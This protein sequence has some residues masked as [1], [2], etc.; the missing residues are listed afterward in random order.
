MQTQGQKFFTTQEIYIY[1][2]MKKKCRVTFTKKKRRVTFTNSFKVFNAMLHSFFFYF[3][4]T[5]HLYWTSWQSFNWFSVMITVW[6]KIHHFDSTTIC[7]FVAYSMYLAFLFRPS[8]YAVKQLIQSLS[9]VALQNI[10][11]YSYM[12]KQNTATKN[13]C[14]DKN[15]KKINIYGPNT[16][17]SG[18]P[19]FA[20]SLP[21]F[22]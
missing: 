18:S 8:I 6:E 7:V 1:T 17:N 13:G 4:I 2:R 9:L 20:N 21:I 3:C 14:L 19:L 5:F 11:K 22:L 10:L 16:K 12:L 15:K